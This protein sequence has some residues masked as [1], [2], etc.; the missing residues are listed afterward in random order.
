[1]GSVGD[2]FDNAMCESF[3]AKL[4]RELLARCRFQTHDQARHAIFE[5]LG[6][7]YNLRRGGPVRSDSFF[8]F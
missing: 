8:D 2:Y 4:E 6:S 5:Y 3:F 7:W 1:M